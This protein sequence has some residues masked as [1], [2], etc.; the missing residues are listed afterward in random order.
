M[1]LRPVSD[2]QQSMLRVAWA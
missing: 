2:T 1:P